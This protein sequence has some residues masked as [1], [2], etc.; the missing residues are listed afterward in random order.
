MIAL[1]REP[2]SARALSARRIL[3]G[4]VVAQSAVSFAEQGLPTLTV[5]IKH[6]LAL[7]A[8]AVGALVSATGLGRVVGFYAAGRAVDRRGERRV[9]FVGAVG[10][11]VCMAAAAGF[12]YTAMLA[13][14]LVAGLFLATAAPAGSKLVFTAVGERRRG[15]AM[16]IRQASVPAGGLAAAAILPTLAGWTSWRTAL[17]VAGAVSALG[18]LV[19]VRLAGFGPRVESAPLATRLALKG[20]GSRPFVLTTLWAA[21]LVGAQYAVLTFLPIDAHVRAGVSSVA[22]ASL[23]IVVQATGVAGRIAWG[24]AASHVPQLRVRALPAAVTVLG[25][26]SAAVLA[27]LPMHRLSGFVVLAVL[28]GISINGW[29][30]LWTHRLTEIAGAE[31]AGTATGVAL[32]LVGLSIAGGTPAYGAIADAAGTMRALWGAVAVALA[33]ALVAVAFLPRLR[34]EPA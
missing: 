20:L 26:G 28:C 31:R 11:G 14:L 27:L 24:F 33:V 12:G 3:V 17:V 9:I 13:V 25:A 1:G 16:G 18:G 30:G 4:A 34:E 21:L 6:D 32:T 7:S 29:Q 15:F 10:T 8:S 2:L 23:L 5:F 22:A 19:L